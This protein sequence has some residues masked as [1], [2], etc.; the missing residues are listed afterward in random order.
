M[1]D[2][3]ENQF[4]NHGAVWWVEYKGKALKIP[5]P[6]MGKTSK[7]LLCIA[8]LL[9]RPFEEISVQILDKALNGPI[10]AIALLLDQQNSSNKIL[11]KTVIN[12]FHKKIHELKNKIEEV[13]VHE[14]NQLIEEKENLEDYVLKHINTHGKS[15]KFSDKDD[16]CRKRICNAI[17]REFERLERCNELDGNRRT[18]L[19]NHFQ[20]SIQTG[21][22][23]CYRP[24]KEIEWEVKI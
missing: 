10:G 17:H 4:I 9:Q 13:D 3:N 12:S 19:V 14:K 15:K 24:E 2:N 23:C 5:E 16:K 22:S 18:E 8:Y 21:Y 20:N 7:G 6:T 1:S 11:D